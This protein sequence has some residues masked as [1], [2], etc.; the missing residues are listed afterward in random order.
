MKFRGAQNT[1][2]YTPTRTE[3]ITDIRKL[4]SVIE[5][6]EEQA[7][8]ENPYKDY[9]PVDL[10]INKPNS[11]PSFPPATL[12]TFFVQREV[13]V[14]KL[15][16]SYIIFPFDGEQFKLRD[17]L[18]HGS[19]PLDSRVQLVQENDTLIGESL[20]LKDT[21]VFKWSLDYLFSAPT[22]LTVME[23]RVFP[24]DV[25]VPDTELVEP[26]QV[27]APT[28]LHSIEITMMQK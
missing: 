10:R 21:N 18:L 14:G 11:T 20:I 19:F 17:I 12:K 5:Q 15:P 2:V 9:K 23:I 27:T 3:D 28:V 4:S 25:P 1:P 7:R 8:L 6:K 22:S 13:E 16:V 26:I 24:G